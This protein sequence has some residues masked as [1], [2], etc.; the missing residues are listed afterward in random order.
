MSLSININHDNLN[1]LPTEERVSIAARL[2]GGNCRRP[3]EDQPSC[4]GLEFKSV[5][6]LRPPSAPVE[7]RC[8]WTPKPASL[9]RWYLTK[10]GSN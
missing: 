9:S 4:Q 8:K 1:E 7:I 10:G 2:P 5:E 6:F 3:R